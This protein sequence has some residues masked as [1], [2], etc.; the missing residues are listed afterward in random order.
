MN[1]YPEKGEISL[2][3]LP[4]RPKD[5]KNRPALVV[6][7]DIR[8]KLANDIIVVPLSTNLRPSPT[9]VLLQEGEGGLPKASMAKCEQVTTIDK[10]LLIRGPFA[11]KVN[12][13]KME[14]IEKAIMIAIGV[15]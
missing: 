13:E 3:N 1:E 2:V 5:I 4:S 8:N 14:E 12:N 15:I 11:G 6:S 10:S 7:L 9:H